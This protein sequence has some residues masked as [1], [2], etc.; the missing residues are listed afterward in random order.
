MFQRR[1]SAACL[2]FAWAFA[3]AVQAHVPILL[4][5]VPPGPED[6][7]IHTGVTL[8]LGVTVGGDNLLKQSVV[9]KYA[10]D[11][12]MGA[13]SGVYFGPG[14]VLVFGR[15]RLGFKQEVNFT[16]ND[17]CSVFD[18]SS[19]ACHFLFAHLNFNSLLLLGVGRSDSP[20]EVVAGLGVAYQKNLALDVDDDTGQSIQR[21]YLGNAHGWIAQLQW[22]RVGLRFTHI[23]Y[24]LPGSPVV[25]DASSGGFFFTW[26]FGE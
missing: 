24:H 14:L 22:N 18:D 21:T 2:L 16:G 9:G 11:D 1:L 15:S 8:D 26:E 19:H 7:P 12:Y 23:L 13:G 3:P 17:S 4:G 25:L 10:Q 6:K 20:W 5:P